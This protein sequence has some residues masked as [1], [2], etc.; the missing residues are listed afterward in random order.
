MLDLVDDAR[1]HGCLR[2]EDLCLGD[3]NDTSFVNFSSTSMA[4]ILK[5]EHSMSDTKDL[6]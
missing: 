2:L 3:F 1:M 4:A 6:H 5:R